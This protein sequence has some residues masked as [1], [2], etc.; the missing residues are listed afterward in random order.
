MDVGDGMSAHAPVPPFG[1]IRFS[2]ELKPYVKH[3]AQTPALRGAPEALTD[4]AR[5]VGL[6]VRF[7]QAPA[8]PLA[9]V[10]K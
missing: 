4:H 10:R 2:V 5:V 3:A 6:R 1:T 7:V 9:H 8:K